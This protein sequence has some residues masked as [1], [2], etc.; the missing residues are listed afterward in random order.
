MSAPQ[1]HR[2]DDPKSYRQNASFVYS[3]EYTAPIL[4]LLD[5]QENDRILDLGCG[6][7]ELT[8]VLASVVQKGH[9]SIYATDVSP[10]MIRAA[11]QSAGAAGISQSCLQYSVADGCSMKEDVE[12]KGFSGQFDKVFSNAAIHWMKT[13][14]QGVVNGVYEA[15]KPG[16]IFAAEF[17]G[18]MNVIGLRAACHHIVRQYGIEPEFVDPWFFPTPEAYRALL[19][20]SDLPQPFEVLHCELVPRP[21]PLPNGVVSFFETFC[22]P[23]LNALDS[24]QSRE[25]AIKDLEDLLRPDMYDPYTKTWTAMYVRLRVKARKP[26]SPAAAH[27]DAE[28][29]QSWAINVTEEQAGK[30]AH[31]PSSPQAQSGVSLLQEKFVD[32]TVLV[33]I[34]DGRVFKGVFTCVDDGKNLIL[35]QAEELRLH[36]GAEG[37]ASSTSTLNTEDR[38]VER[39]GIGMVMIKGED[40]KKIEVQTDDPSRPRRPQRNDSGDAIS[41][42]FNDAFPSDPNA[43]A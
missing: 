33:H 3:N 26:I 18:F 8:Q 21:T 6:S 14:P 34:P 16:G 22:G 37:T 38:V 31:S 27:A 15:L 20:S 1:H 42:A 19:T 23:F 24:D 12:Q 29:T 4:T 25:Q 32:R 40:V 17:G 30:L 35:S 43:Y 11:I 9:G 41:G 10:D 13:C 28:A 2:S 36:T 5:P 7:G 39:R